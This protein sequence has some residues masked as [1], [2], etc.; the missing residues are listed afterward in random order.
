MWREDEF[1]AAVVNPEPGVPAGITSW[2]SPRPLRRFA[3][4]RNNVRAALAEALAVR[5]PVVRR[6]VGEAFFRAMAREFVVA[7]L[8]ASPVLIHYGGP[9]PAFIARYPGADGVPYLADVAR[10]ES[11]YWQAYH[12]ADAV[13]LS[14][15]AFAAIDG[16]RLAGAR[17]ILI[18]SA[19]ILRSRY[20]FVS[21]WRTNTEDEDVRPVDL[22]EWED[23]LVARPDLVVDVR[24][25][26]PGAATFLRA[27]QAGETL[28][29]AMTQ[30]S[31]ETVAFDLTANLKGLIATRIVAEITV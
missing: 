9:F 1:A 16:E 22:G 18:P 2:T 3:V 23:A 10:L 5:Y 15:E 21:I 19:S 30:A 8:P 12:A 20:P 6:L 28:A 17:F 7:N 4:Y 27:L 25:L 31:A 13:P 26:P 14:V 24:H 29:T 11:A